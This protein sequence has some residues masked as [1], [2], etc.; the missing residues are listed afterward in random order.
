MS[1][2]GSSKG[3]STSSFS[4]FSARS[5]VLCRISIR[6]MTVGIE[7]VGMSLRMSSISSNVEGHGKVY[8]SSLDVD[9]VSPIRSRFVAGT[10]V[11]SS[12]DSS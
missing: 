1:T 4:R 9:G 6:S 3:G 5:F 11:S 10:I 12:S 7:D 8:A 2:S